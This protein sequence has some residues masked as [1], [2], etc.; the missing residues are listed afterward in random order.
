VPNSFLVLTILAAILR[1]VVA[2]DTDGASRAF[3]LYLA[4]VR[5]VQSWSPETIEIEASLPKLKKHG[6]LRA[7]RSTNP[8]GGVD[9]QVIEIA[10]DR[11]VRQQVIER[12]LTAQMTAAEIP[13]SATAITPANYEFR[14]QGVVKVGDKLAYTFRINPHKKRVG[15]ITGEL[16]LDAETGAAVRQSG[17]LVK[18]P[19]L[20]V[21]SVGIIRETILREGVARMLSTH[22]TVDTR[23]VGVADLTVTE[24]PLEAT[25]AYLV[26]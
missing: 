1:P 8:E 9:Y 15:L 18:S 26:P 12:Y 22:L 20:F 6:H 23:L 25:D 17:R 7:V 10:G 21:K 3:A 24:M 4:G 16:W 5:H 13:A 2:E 14:Y 11:M 19:S